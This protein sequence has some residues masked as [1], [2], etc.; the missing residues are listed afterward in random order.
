MKILECINVYR[1]NFFASFCK[2]V[3][4]EGPY[5][6]GLDEGDHIVEKSG[7]V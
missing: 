3:L 6:M 7:M 4:Y 5:E 1:I 2:A